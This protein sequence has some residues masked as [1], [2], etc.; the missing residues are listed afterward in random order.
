MIYLF[1]ILPLAFFLAVL[2]FTDSFTLVTWKHILWS[3]CAG[4]AVCFAALIISRLVDAL[5]LFFYSPLIEETLKFAVLLLLVGRRRIVFVQQALCYGAAIGAGFAFAENLLYINA[6]NAMSA[7]TALFRGMGTAVMHMACPMIAATF[8][9]CAAML[10]E[11]GDRGQAI[12]MGLAGYA[13]ALGIHALFNLMLLPLWVQL[14]LTL[15]V[16]AALVGAISS[17]NERRVC[18]W[19]DQ[20]INNDISLLRAIQSGR[21]SETKQGQY[22]LTVRSQFAPET[23]AD[24]MCYIRLYLELIIEDKSRLIMRE[25]GMELPRSIQQVQEHNA[26]V[27]EFL[28]LRRRIGKTGESVL[29]PI[30]RV[31]RD[32]AA[33]MGVKP[34]SKA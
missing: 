32:D 24:M 22:L 30:V 25:A 26:A 3:F 28:E 4:V 21:L 2:K 16:F 5:G 29:R 1:S 10:R 7:G 34:S 18:R 9:S 19:L 8:L 6:F 15:V 14:A 31:T 12:A 13:S 20:S 23:V 11:A 27:M 17:Y 33:L